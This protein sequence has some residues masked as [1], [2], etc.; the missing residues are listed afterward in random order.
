MTTS[1]TLD[2]IVPK[3][4]ARGMLSFRE[5]AIMPQLVPNDFSAEAARHGDRVDIPIAG[6]VAVDDVEPSHVAPAPSA[7]NIETHSLTLDNWKKVSFFLTDKEM[8]QIDA[9]Q[10]FVPYQMQ[11]AVAALA[12][13]MNRS[14]FDDIHRV[15]HIRGRKNT[16]LFSTSDSDASKMN[17]KTT[18]AIE[19]RRILNEEAAPK[20]GRFA[21]LNYEQEAHALALSEF[22]DASMSGDR[23]VR[24]QGE[25]GRKYGID[26][27]SS[28]HLPT[29]TGSANVDFL[30][31]VEGAATKLAK[32][33]TSLTVTGSD[34]A[35]NKG[36]MIYGE[37]DDTI[38]GVLAENVPHKSG[39]AVTLPLS[40]PTTRDVT[41]TEKLNVISKY[42]ECLVFQRNAFAFATRPLAS[43]AEQHGFGNRIMSVTDPASGLSLRL[44]I[45][46]QYKQT[47]W[48]F[49]ALWGVKLIKPQFAIRLLAAS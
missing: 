49:D 37:T 19:A 2:A 38:I 40:G 23:E 34:G 4:L 18:H 22:A 17:Y 28:D 6:S 20:E 48:E 43:M 47:V 14:F 16:N 41:L 44:E 33:A 27:F 9:D 3:I 11:E 25:I 36:D 46:R 26:W 45:S 13:S 21:I 24:L 15:T 12:E 32:G 42:E 29:H 35:Y 5:K 10:N 8:M 7:S 39:Q 1:N 31:S 30:V